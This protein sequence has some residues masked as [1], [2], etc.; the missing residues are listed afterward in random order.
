MQRS[1]LN[2]RSGLLIDDLSTNGFFSPE[3]LIEIPSFAVLGEGGKPY[4]FDKDPD[5]SQFAVECQRLKDDVRFTEIQLEIADMGTDIDQEGLKRT[6]EN[7]AATLHRKGTLKIEYD[8]D[9]WFRQTY[10]LDIS[11]LEKLEQEAQ[12]ELANPL[13]SQGNKRLKIGGF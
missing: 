12:A 5:L 10:F 11:V 7:L 1:G 6:V 4:S 2:H 8:L 13:R 9:F 3:R